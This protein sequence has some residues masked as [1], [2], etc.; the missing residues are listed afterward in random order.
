MSEAASVRKILFLSIILL[1]SSLS[2]LFIDSSTLQ[3]EKSSQVSQIV[4]VSTFSSGSSTETIMADIGGTAAIPHQTGYRLLNASVAIETLP[5]STTQ[6]LYQNMINAQSFGTF[7]N[8]SVTPQG[9]GLPN[10]NT[11]PPGSGN[12]STTILT[13]VQWSGSHSYDSLDLRCGIAACG[14]ITATGSLTIY[15]RTL[16]VAAGTTISANALSSA[17]SGSGGSVSATSNGYSN[18]GGGAG[19]GGGGGSGGGSSGTGTGGSTYGNSTE[20]GSQGGSVTSSNHAT[21]SGGN[22]GGYITIIANQIDVNGTI[23]SNGGDG[24]NGQ[25]ITG[26]SGPGG[27]GAGGGSGGSIFIKANTVNV[28]QNGLIEATGGDGGDGASSFCNGACIGMYDGGDGGG[29]GG[30]GRINIMTQV[31]NFNNGGTISLSAGSGGGGGQPYGT[32]VMGTAGASGTVGVSSSSTWIG[33]TIVSGVSVDDGTFITDP[34]LPNGGQIIDGWVNHTSTI[35]LNSS[36]IF[37]YRYTISGLANNTSTDW[38][39]WNIGNLSSQ[40]LPRL[41]ALQFSYQ[42]NR[43]ST[44]SPSLSG[45]SLNW[46]DAHVV[47]NLEVTLSGGSTLLG[48]LSQ[49]IGYSDFAT[50]VSNSNSHIVNISIPTNTIATSSLNLWIDWPINSASDTI[51]VMLGGSTVYSGTMDSQLGGVDVELTAQQLI[52]AWPSSGIIGSDGIEMS[53]LVLNI[54][55][56]MAVQLDAKHP[57]LSWS[58]VHNLDLKS[59]LTLHAFASCSDWYNA[60]LSCLPQFLLQ[61]SGDTVPFNF[62][63]YA[64]TLSN[65]SVQ[66]IDDIAPQLS[67]VDHRISGSIGQPIRVGD[68][69]AVTFGDVIG[70]TTLS[71]SAWI[72]QEDSTKPTTTNQLAYFSALGR[73]YTTFD[74]SQFDHSTTTQHYIGLELIDAHDNVLL[75]E[76]AYAFETGPVIPSV[77]SIAMRAANNSH[78]A[79]SESEDSSSWELDDD[80]FIFS[81][82]S[83]HNRSDLSASVTLSPSEGNSQLIMLNWDQNE[84]AYTGHWNA[85]HSDLKT[86]QLEVDLS[87]ITGQMAE[88]LDGYQNG[89]D[90]SFSLVDATGPVLTVIDH[91]EIILIGDEILVQLQWL[92]DPSELINGYVIVAFNGSSVENQTISPIN[93]GMSSLLLQ[94]TDWEI[95]FYQLTVF[96]FDEYGNPSQIGINSSMFEITPLAP[97]VSGD[98]NGWEFDSNNLNLTISGQ[99]QFRFTQGQVTITSAGTTLLDNQSIQDGDWSLEV[100][101][102]SIL[103]ETIE[104][105]IR[106]CDATD[107]NDCEQYSTSINAST[108]IQFSV[109]IQCTEVTQSLQMN[110]SETLVSC[111]IVNSNGTYPMQVVLT[112]LQ[113][114]SFIQEGTSEGELPSQGQLELSLLINTGSEQGTWSQPWVL[115]ITNRLG[116][117]SVL[118]QSSTSFTVIAQQQDENLTQI[119]TEGSSESSMGM[120]AIIVAIIAVICIIATIGLLKLRK[121]DEVQD[122]TKRFTSEF[123]QAQYPQH[124]QVEQPVEQAVS[125]QQSVEQPQQQPQPTLQQNQPVTP[126]IDAIPTSTDE[127]GYEWFTEQNGTN[128]YRLQAS[129]SEWYLHQP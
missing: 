68:T 69:F 12:N 104:L 46:D 19:H 117:V 97:L 16:V 49:S 107:G 90:Y 33:Y 27:S 93:T 6:T 31:S 57:Q 120:T 37:T 112:A 101:L 113:A 118:N 121:V 123:D 52:N 125:E 105:Q 67:S 23:Q 108:S 25:A 14:S 126:A 39:E 98:I 56:T 29:G 62:Q 3:L 55:T 32:G 36:L 4:D 128:W 42:F 7:N 92:S 63:G 60:T 80:G 77:T 50:I 11:G 109:E 21:A 71:G 48:P 8:T 54:S 13:A 95:G 75:V 35:P 40:I 61:L 86:W 43:T 72:Y 88:D 83:L 111:I 1:I 122:D 106:V 38:S 82:T 100:S 45:I 70:E 2:P 41:T 94:T 74:S 66:W 81:V 119:T 44:L 103:Q 5:Y 114:S 9:V 30:G 87:E 89:V 64:L 18:G 116:Q 15:V 28:G 129:G 65:L 26:G 76:Q 84:S 24:A 22:G 110:T 51:E 78:N 17:G 91:D 10:T 58:W 124:Q 53:Q 73:Y 115:S 85:D 34:W 79:I 99:H 96:L 127:S 59:S 20:A 102:S 47:D